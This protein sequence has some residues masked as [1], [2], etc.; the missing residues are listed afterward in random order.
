MRNFAA[1]VLTDRL[2]APVQVNGI[3]TNN[4]R[5][6]LRCDPLLV[7]LVPKPVFLCYRPLVVELDAFAMLDLKL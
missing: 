5:R 1:L 7:F 4:T 3:R 2:T 6:A